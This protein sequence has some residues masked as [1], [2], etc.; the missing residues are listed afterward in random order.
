MFVDEEEA[1]RI[2]LLSPMEREEELL[3]CPYNNLD[4]PDIVSVLHSFFIIVVFLYFYIVA[5]LLIFY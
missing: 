3:K 2:V 1:E 5:L 4:S